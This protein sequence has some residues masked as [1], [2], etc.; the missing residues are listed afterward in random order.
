MFK[1]F[2]RGAKPTGD[3]VVI[4][5]CD[6]ASFHRCLNAITLPIAYDSH[7][8]KELVGDDPF[9]NASAVNLSSRFCLKYL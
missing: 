8:V 5:A 2:W 4:Y 9:I 3:N 7:V 1:E 6:Y